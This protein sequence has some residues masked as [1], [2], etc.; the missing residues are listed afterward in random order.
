MSERETTPTQSLLL[1]LKEE[2]VGMREGYRFL[3]EKRLILASEILAELARYQ[4]EQRAFESDYAAASAALQEAVVRHGVEELSLYPPAPPIGGEM[5]LKPRS[6]LGVTVYDLTC[7]M[8]EPEP[9]PQTALLSPEAERCRDA[10]RALIPRAAHLAA[11]A[12][13]LERLREDYA[14]TARR[15]RAMEDVLLPELDETLKAVEGALEEL[16]REEA[17]RARRLGG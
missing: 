9:A 7:Q 17:V 2:R 12:G 11:L 13:N 1:E 16:E 4:A 14:R 8:A 5:I 6:V 10:F 3:D 15:A